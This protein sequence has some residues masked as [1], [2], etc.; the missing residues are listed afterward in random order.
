MLADKV[1]RFVI[2]VIFVNTFDVLTRYH[3]LM[4]AGFGKA[5]CVLDDFAF[6]IVNDTA[7]LRSIDNQF[8]FFFRM[9][10]VVFVTGFDAHQF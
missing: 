2:A 8:D 5:N 10:V 3:N 6:G 9:G 7:F 4:S 1:H